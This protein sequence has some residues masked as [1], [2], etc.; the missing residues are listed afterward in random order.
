MDFQWE[1]GIGLLAGQT[2]DV[3][4]PLWQWKL[5]TAVGWNQGNAAFRRPQLRGSW[6]GK[7]DDDSTWKI[8]IALADPIARD[9]DGVGD[10]DGEDAG[11]PDLQGRLNFTFRI[12][13]GVPKADVGI[14][15]L[16]GKREADLDSHDDEYTAWL[17]GIDLMIPVAKGVSILAE[18][19]DSQAASSYNASLAQDYNKTLDREI[20]AR[21]GFVNVKWKIDRFWMVVA[22]Y[23]I[24]DPRNKDLSDGQRSWNSS[25][26]INVR[27]WITKWATV[28]LEYDRME[29]DYLG[30]DDYCNHRLQMSFKLKF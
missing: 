14:G 12:F 2:W 16:Y 18:F 23:G 13:D 10:D 26:F 24:C 9:I 30:E 1:N 6:V 7:I 4:L 22:G 15:A 21:G 20:R 28:G 27:Y 3:F 5:N 29:T 17:V 25:G 11:V 8:A 19:Y